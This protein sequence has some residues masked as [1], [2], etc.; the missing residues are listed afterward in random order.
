MGLQAKMRGPLKAWCGFAG[1]AGGLLL[2]AGLL[3]F[4]GKRIRLFTL[5]YVVDTDKDGNVVSADT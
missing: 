1:I 2:L 4:I 3:F 5:R